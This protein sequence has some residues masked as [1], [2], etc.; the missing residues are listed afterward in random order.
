MR[1]LRVKDLLPMMAFP[2]VRAENRSISLM[3][4]DSK[5]S[6]TREELF[7]LTAFARCAG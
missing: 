7:K 6:N 4:E 1:A 5:T 3:I 2:V